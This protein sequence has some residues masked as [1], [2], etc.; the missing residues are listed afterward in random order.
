MEPINILEQ[1]RGIFSGKSEFK[2][3]EH[4]VD[5]KTQIEFFEMSAKL[6]NKMD[7]EDVY[8]LRNE[9]FEDRLKMEEKKVLLAALSILDKVDVFR[10]I[11]QYAAAPDSELSDWSKLALHESKML[12]ESSLL[13][14]KQVCIATGM[15]GKDNKFRYFGGLI[16]LKEKFTKLQR[17]VIK[18]ELAFNITKF[19]G[20]VEEVKFRNN[21]CS[22]I[23]CIPLNRRAGNFLLE[24]IGEC[25]ALGEFLNDD[26]I[27]TNVKKMSFSEVNE[28]MKDSD[29][30]QE[31]S[32]IDNILDSQT[33]DE[34]ED[35]N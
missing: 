20:D 30:E 3:L 13:E 7:R 31:E 22:I 11:E 12:I 10:I 24:V 32:L 9:I 28:A 21:I 15:G 18:K 33:P 4:N 14:K 1:L 29:N 5:M 6:R 26:F 2:I 8:N 34:L 17:E 27:L 25:N 35:E 23:F 16:S 19:E